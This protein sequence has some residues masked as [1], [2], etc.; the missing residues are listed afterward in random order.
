MTALKLAS[1]LNKYG[2]ATVVKFATADGTRSD[3]N[4]VKR[5]TENGVEILIVSETQIP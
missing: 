4:Y 1:I 5:V 3:I 2:P